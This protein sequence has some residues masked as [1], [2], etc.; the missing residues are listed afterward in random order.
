MLY[1]N[2]CLVA[3]LLVGSLGAH[4]QSPV[5]PTLIR[6]GSSEQIRIAHQ[7]GRVTTFAAEKEVRIAWTA[8]ALLNGPQPPEAHWAD[9]QY[10]WATDDQV[11]TTRH[12]PTASC[13]VSGSMVVVC[14]KTDSGDT[15][16]ESW[17][18]AWPSP[19]P[20]PSTN[21]QTGVTSVGIALPSLGA[22]TELYK[23]TVIGR[24]LVRNVTSLR[25][26]MGAPQHLVLQFDDSNDIYSL[27][28]ATKTLTLL[29]SSSSPGGSLGVLP[30]TSGQD[31][32]LFG[33][34]IG[35]S[36]TGYSYTFAETRWGSSMAVEDPNF[37]TMVLVDSDRDGVIDN[38]RQYTNAQ[39]K[40]DGWT[41]LVN[42][43]NY[44]NP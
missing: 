33:N 26:S 24:A 13:V 10:E 34:K 44:W 11:F 3:A 39:R 19:M 12:Y 8:M 4:A 7:A 20:A 18:L 43:A 41:E 30:L 16:I 17:L 15:L 37:V 2:S 9:S 23:A 22:R 36:E 1:S 14:G 31:C 40:A 5:P 42:F 38:V 21:V 29:G 6:G 28:L 25:R 35:G 27:D 32:L